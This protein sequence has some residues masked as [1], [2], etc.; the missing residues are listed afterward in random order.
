MHM[1]PFSFARSCAMMLTLALAAS[2][3]SAAITGNDWL[4]MY[5][6]DSSA[7]SAYV[8]GAL[9]S[10]QITLIALQARNQTMKICL[11]AQGTTYSQFVDIMRVWIE[12]NPGRRHE[13]AAALF[14]IAVADSFPCK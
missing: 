11:P 13:M 6:E 7:G 12:K 10:L 8:M 4:R 9:D 1:T 14:T 3:S 2:P 5:K